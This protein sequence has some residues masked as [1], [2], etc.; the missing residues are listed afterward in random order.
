MPTL[1]SF[2]IHGAFCAVNRRLLPTER[3]LAFLDDIHVICRPQRVSDVCGRSKKSCVPFTGAGPS[4][5]TQIWN[6][7]GLLPSGRQAVAAAARISDR[8]VV[9]RGDPTLLFAQ[10]RGGSP[11]HPL[12]H[13]EFLKAHL[14]GVINSHSVLWERNLQSAWF[15]LVFFA[16]TR[17]NFLLR[18]TEWPTSL[19]ETTMPP[20]GAA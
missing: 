9:W 5:K 11:R 7:S 1:F 2:G 6:R 4:G 16:A 19:Q 18:S 10:Q 8:G 17:A 12:G 13:T 20:C 14:R 15:L 3:L